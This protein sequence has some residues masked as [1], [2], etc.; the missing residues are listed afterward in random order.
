MIMSIPASVGFC[1]DM[2]AEVCKKKKGKSVVQ[3]EHTNV[4]MLPPGRWQCLNQCAFP[5]LLPLLTPNDSEMLMVTVVENWIPE[6]AK[7]V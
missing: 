6:P 7:L 3:T 1:G 4:L 2:K 5:S